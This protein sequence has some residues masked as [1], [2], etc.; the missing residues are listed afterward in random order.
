MNDAG[1]TQRQFARRVG[2]SHGRIS[3][4]AKDGLPPLSSGRIHVDAALTWLEQNLDHARSS[5]AKGI[6]AAPEPEPAPAPAPDSKPQTTSTPIRA[7]TVTETKPASG[8]MTLAEARRQHEIVR[9]AM[10]RLRFDKDR[11]RLVNKDEIG[12]VIFNRARRE[13][14]AHLSWVI[15]V[16]PQLADELSV[17]P[18]LMFTALDRHLR[19]HLAILSKTPLFELPE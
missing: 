6:T 11:G 15:R 8:G 7:P 9:V 5:R 17:D 13:R 18:A 10:A 1:E 2:L 4:L 19:E 14:N 16:A 12:I 3:Q